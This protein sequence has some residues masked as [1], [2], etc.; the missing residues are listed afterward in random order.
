MLNLGLDHSPIKE[1]PEEVMVLVQERE[2]LRRKG[3]WKE[4]DRLRD[5]VRKRGYEVRDTSLGPK[6]VR[7]GDINFD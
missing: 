1:I 2:S 6:V 4:S 3:Q 5:E 7:R